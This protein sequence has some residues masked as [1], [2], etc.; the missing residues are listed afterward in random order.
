LPANF[1]SLVGFHAGDAVT[2][3]GQT[4]N[5]RFELGVDYFMDIHLGSSKA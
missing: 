2:G 4:G 5:G 3:A 1:P